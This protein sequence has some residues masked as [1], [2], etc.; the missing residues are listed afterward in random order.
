[1]H[2]LTDADFNQL[3]ANPNAQRVH[4]ADAVMRADRYDFVGYHGTDGGV[5]PAMNKTGISPVFAGRTTGLMR[6]IGFYIARDIRLAR[7]YAENDENPDPALL[8]VYI[9][10]FRAMRSNH[11]YDFGVLKGSSLAAPTPQKMEIWKRDME[12]V[13]RPQC[14][15]RISIFRTSVAA[16]SNP[17][18]GTAMRPV[19]PGAREDNHVDETLYRTVHGMLHTRI[20]QLGEEIDYE[21]D[22]VEKARLT[23]KREGFRGAYDR[24][25]ENLRTLE[26][27]RANAM[28]AKTLYKKTPYRKTPSGSWEI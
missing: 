25:A 13:I 5:L 10:D 2:P 7:D 18:P 14:Y 4:A 16:E 3:V 12:L 15:G 17:I 19:S 26:N 27:K 8:R 11:H 22:P 23:A 28:Y 6:G 20:Y 1:M 21:D 24:V 9:R